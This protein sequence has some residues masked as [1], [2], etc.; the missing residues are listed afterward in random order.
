MVLPWQWV[1]TAG[2]KER[3]WRETLTCT[4]VLSAFTRMV[5]NDERARA[6]FMTDGRAAVRS[7]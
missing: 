4:R 5:E 2:L 3:F 7:Y 1:P 6:P